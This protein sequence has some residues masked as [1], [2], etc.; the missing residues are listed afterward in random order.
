MAKAAP[1]NKKDES[2]DLSRLRELIEMM[3]EH[4]VTEVK[5][6]KGD[7]KWHLRR[8]PK[9]VMQMMPTGVAPVAPAVAAPVAAVASETSSTPETSNDIFIVSPIVGT[10]YQSPSPED[11]PFAKV[12]TTVNTETIV[13]IVEAMKVFNQ[14]PSEVNGTIVEILAKDG[15]AVDF[16]QPLFRLKP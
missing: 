11:P 16:N 3:E 15:D 6:N 13:C 10:F 8:G 4:G 5:L 14:I 7:E 9:E 2:F 12:G 1:R